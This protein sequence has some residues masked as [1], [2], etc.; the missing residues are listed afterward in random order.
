MRALLRALC[1]AAAVA[2]LLSRT[3]A[4]APPP[5]PRTPHI[6][7]GQD[8]ASLFLTFTLPSPVPPAGAPGAP[9]VHI[10]ATHITL[11]SLAGTPLT[12]HEASLFLRE[13]VVPE[14][15]HWARDRVGVRATLRKRQPH[16]FDRLL[17]RLLT[18]HAA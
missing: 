13:D 9:E 3:A 18:W 8:M 11:R 6:Q 16:R 12:A 7:W 5:P 2:A 10:N 1:A 4:S 14:A 15:S 17:V